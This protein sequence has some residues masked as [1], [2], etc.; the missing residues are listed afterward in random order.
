MRKPAIGRKYPWPVIGKIAALIPAMMI[1]LLTGP[2]AAAEFTLPAVQKDIEKRYQSVRHISRDE[3]ARLMQKNPDDLLL[4]DVREEEEFRVSHLKG[5]ARLD[6]GSW[7]SE[8]LKK[9][10]DQVSGKTIVFYC[11][12]GMRSSK[13]ADYVA[14]A[15]K[16]RGAANIYNLEEG[17]FGW[18][19]HQLPMFNELGPTY[20]IHPFNDHWGQLIN[21]RDFWRKVP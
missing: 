6:P 3:L 8:V 21:F 7:K 9:Y 16:E 13:M 11:S 4:F 14:D 10:G 17:L 20:F 15:L 5:A 18:S 2:V 1:S 19:N 12:V